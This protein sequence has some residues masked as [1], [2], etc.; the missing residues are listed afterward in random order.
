MYRRL[1][2]EVSRTCVF[3][4]EAKGGYKLFSY[5]H[6][7]HGSNFCNNVILTAPKDRKTI[8]QFQRSDIK[9]S[10]KIT[11]CFTE[12]LFHYWFQLW[13]SFSVIYHANLK[14]FNENSKMSSTM[15]HDVISKM[16][17]LQSNY[18]LL[19]KYPEKW[20]NFL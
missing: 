13:Q 16:I 15:N 1:Y 19:W 8:R 5:Y 11:L 10:F 12:V 18:Y 4:N 14:L 7:C 2:C 20:L 17:S 6:N 3:M 9:E